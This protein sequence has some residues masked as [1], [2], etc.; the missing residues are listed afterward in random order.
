L[1]VGERPPSAD[2]LLGW[3][4]A[5]WG[6]S[7]DGSAEMV[8]GAAERNDHPRYDKCPKGP[9]SFTAPQANNVCDLFHFWSYHRNGANFLFCDG[10]VHFIP[11]AAAPIMPALA[12]RAGGE[13][14]SID[15]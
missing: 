5:G 9:Y 4:Y 14:V 10:S 2:G 7:K 13:A 6:Q 1:I 11:Y 8:L 12:T 15:F 3:W